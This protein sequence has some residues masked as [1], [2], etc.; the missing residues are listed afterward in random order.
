[1]NSEEIKNYSA[2]AFFSSATVLILIG[3]VMVSGV[4]RPGID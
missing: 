3:I 4:F 1:M 2:I